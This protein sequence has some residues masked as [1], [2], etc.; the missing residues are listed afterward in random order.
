MCTVILL[1]SFCHLVAAPRISSIS[2]VP[3]CTTF[4]F[5]SCLGKSFVCITL[6]VTKSWQYFLVFLRC[7]FGKLFNLHNLSV[8]N[9]QRS[10][11]LCIT[12]FVDNALSILHR[13]SSLYLR[14]ESFSDRTTCPFGTASVVRLYACP[15]SLLRPCQY[16]LVFLCYTLGKLFKLRTCPPAWN[17][18]SSSFVCITFFVTL[19]VHRHLILR[20]IFGKCRC[21]VRQANLFG[22]SFVWQPQTPLPRLPGYSYCG[23]T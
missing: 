21:I 2:S 22:T 16:F 3:N 11:F 13:I 17:C 9:C 15:F 8:R 10:S 12:F 6:L 20:C 4:R 5:P 14:L 7:T 23:E 1:Y 18:L 19:S